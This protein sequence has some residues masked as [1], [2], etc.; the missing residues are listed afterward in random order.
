MATVER[1]RR[2]WWD[3]EDDN[4]RGDAHGGGGDRAAKSIDVAAVASGQGPRLDPT[5]ADAHAGAS[6]RQ[7]GGASTLV[8]SR[9]GDRQ[10]RQAASAYNV[11]SDPGLRSGI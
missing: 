7:A 5:E 10:G 11:V 2:W 4:E 9:R 1:R 3:A 8:D 6:G